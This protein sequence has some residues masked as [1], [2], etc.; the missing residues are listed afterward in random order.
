MKSPKL[1]CLHTYAVVI[2]GCHN[3][4]SEVLSAIPVSPGSPELLLFALL[5][6][7]WRFRALTLEPLCQLCFL[8][9]S[10]PSFRGA[11]GR[12]SLLPRLALKQLSVRWLELQVPGFIF[13]VIQL[14]TVRSIRVGGSLS[15]DLLIQSPDLAA[16]NICRLSHY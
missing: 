4:D 15:P 12:I 16:G 6:Y 14:P 13:P 8:P 10:E 5:L 9:Y 3:N 7:T 2:K 1:P 11:E